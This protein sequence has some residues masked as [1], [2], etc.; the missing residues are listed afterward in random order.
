MWSTQAFMDLKRYGLDVHLVSDPVPGQICIIPY[1]YL[2]PKDLLFKSYVVSCR[3]DTP[4]PKLCNQW[5]VINHRQVRDPYHHYLPHRPQPN[6]R[7]RDASRGAMVRNLVF[8]GHSYNLAAPF[9]TPEFLSALQ[10]LGIQLRMSTEDSQAT[11]SDWADYTQG[12]VVIAVRNNTVY[13]I[14]LKP[15]LKLVNAWFAGCPAILGPEPAYQ[16][17]RQSELDYIEVRTPEEA[18]AALKR[19]QQNPDLYLAMIENG[20]QRAQEYTVDHIIQKWYHL[21]AGPI[22]QGYEQWLRQSS[23]EMHIGRPLRYVWQVIDQKIADRVY[24]YR[25]K[26]GPRII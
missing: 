18:I 22:T 13:D 26:H 9:R 24:Q 23:L 5:I 10:E 21:L 3:Y 15:A 11:F 19:L 2:Q 1:Y 20:F 8:K 14:S 17:L 12:D 25:I 4:Y 16:H 6:L 7:P